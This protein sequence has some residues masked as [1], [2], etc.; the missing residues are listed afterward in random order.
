[1]SHGLEE[2]N[3]HCQLCHQ[4]AKGLMILRVYTSESRYERIMHGI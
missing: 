4:S 2:V 3:M 1:M